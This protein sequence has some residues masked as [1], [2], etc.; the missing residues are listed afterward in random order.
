MPGT[1]LLSLGTPWFSSPTGER[2][3]PAS[4]DSPTHLASTL[5]ASS[6]SMTTESN[7]SW[8]NSETPTSIT[9]RPAPEIPSSSG[10]AWIR[11]DAETTTQ[12]GDKRGE[13]VTSRASGRGRGRG[14]KNRGEDRSRGEEKGRGEER[15]KAEEEGSGEITGAE[16][17]GEIQVSRRPVGT[18]KPRERSRERSRERGH[19]RGHSTTTTTTTTTD[20]ASTTADTTT[21]ID[22]TT[23]TTADTT[24]TTA[25][26]ITTTADMITTIADTTAAIADISTTTTITTDR[27]HEPI[28]M[29][30][31]GTESD[32]PTSKSSPALP[33][34]E[35]SSL[36]VSDA[37]YQTLSS[38][39]S[40]PPSTMPSVSFFKPSQSEAES[41]FLPSSI[42]SSFSPTLTPSS[43]PLHPQTPSFSPSVPS[44]V[45]SETQTVGLGDK[46][47]SPHSKNQ[48]SSTDAL[49]P[50][51]LVPVEKVVVNG[52]LDNPLS[53]SGPPDEEE[54][55]W[56]HSVGSG[57][58]LPV[59]MEEESSST[60]GGG[61]INISTTALSPTCKHLMSVFRYF[62]M[63]LVA[64][65][66]RACS[67]NFC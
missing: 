64:F 39:P 4:E 41:H 34:A 5:A 26:M 48:E 16:A 6:I 21:T 60:G 66:F 59:T 67:C 37:P 17:K 9:S 35:K 62:V 1:G 57:A 23:T 54:P 31:S 30:T 63:P 14:K 61:G 11:V 65:T 29:T 45:P 58:L 15:G 44:N 12:P 22:D 10:D 27:P 50:L 43:P 28:D 20:T 47:T 36:S 19:R 49:T 8:E 3:T 46:A 32:F 53:L 18:S 56:S 24:T 13:T 7:K 51:H 25:D 42:P 55:A 38:S 40:A 2:T 33:Q 52:S